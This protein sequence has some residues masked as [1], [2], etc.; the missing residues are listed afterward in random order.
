MDPDGYLSIR[1]RDVKY[2]I[3]AIVVTIPALKVLRMALKNRATKKFNKS[4]KTPHIRKALESSIDSGLSQVNVR[5]KK[6]N[7]YSHNN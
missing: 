7:Y 5:K 4:L 6:K 3:N 1:L 2:T